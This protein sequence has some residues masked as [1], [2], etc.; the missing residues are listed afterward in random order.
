MK[1]V[2]LIF[3][4]TL[5]FLLSGCGEKGKT[6]SKIPDI[7]NSE[8]INGEVICSNTGMTVTEEGVI[9]P[10]EMQDGGILQY[11]DYHTEKSYPLCSNVNCAHTDNTCDAWFDSMVLGPT[12]YGNRIYLFAQNVESNSW[13]FLSMDADG[14]NRKKIAELKGTDFSGDYLMPSGVFWYQEDLVTFPIQCGSW[15]TGEEWQV[16]VAMDLTDGKVQTI[17]KMDT[18]QSVLTYVNGSCFMS[19]EE[20]DE[21]VLDEEEYYKKMGA[22]ADYDNYYRE[23]YEAHHQTIYYLLDLASGESTDL[24]TVSGDKDPAEWDYDHTADNG[25]YYGT[26]GDIIY[27]IDIAGKELITV[28]QSET[29]KS[30]ECAADGNIFFLELDETRENVVANSYV[31]M[32]TKKV[33]EL[34]GRLSDGGWVRGFSNGYFAGESQNGYICIAKEDFYNSEFDR[35]CIMK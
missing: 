10:I 1:R 28:Y 4:I 6:E 25:I 19:R 15:D 18:D 30:I 34:K 27:G 16:L 29:P 21:S 11:Y 32:E 31:N 22:D 8:V 17:G 24:L 12:I 13:T 14:T 9:F 5:I 20:W 7:S 3:T 26:W 2:S 35:V 23:W 33:T